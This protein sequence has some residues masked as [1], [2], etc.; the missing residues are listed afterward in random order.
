[1]ETIFVISKEYIEK[2]DVLLK[3]SA[4]A[5]LMNV[6]L[7]ENQND[8]MIVKKGDTDIEQI[9]ISGL[10]KEYFEAT[11]RNGNFK[12]DYGCLMTIDFY[13]EQKL[14]IS[15]LKLLF[16]ELPDILIYSEIGPA[17]NSPFVFRENHLKNFSGADSY[18]LFGNAPQDLSHPA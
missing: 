4:I 14:V 5:G 9:E 11:I 3:F 17:L 1:M 16:K 7:I 13:S 6:E 12:T 2:D 15:F 10:N 18:A 8:I